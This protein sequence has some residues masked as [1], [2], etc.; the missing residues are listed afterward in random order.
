MAL[1]INHNIPIPSY[2][3]MLKVIFY[4]FYKILI[5]ITY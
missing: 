3:R 1:F 2:V 4:Y 5:F